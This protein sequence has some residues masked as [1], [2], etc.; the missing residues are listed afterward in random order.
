MEEK[1]TRKKILKMEH[2]CSDVPT[3]PWIVANSLKID[4][5]KLTGCIWV[6]I[7]LTIQ[8][9]DKCPGNEKK[10]LKI[11]SKHVLLSTIV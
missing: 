8:K 10:K 5:R 1:T 6:E 2:P 3:C 9:V 11:S 4:H 7:Y